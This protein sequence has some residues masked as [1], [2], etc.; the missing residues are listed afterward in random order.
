MG[1]DAR[2]VGKAPLTIHS[3]YQCK[4][5]Q[6]CPPRRGGLA[7]PGP[8]A[9]GPENRSSVNCQAC[10]FDAPASEINEI[11]TDPKRLRP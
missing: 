2:T 5:Y 11:L 6:V 7:E 3:P 10:R 8:G 4:A 1:D 9:P